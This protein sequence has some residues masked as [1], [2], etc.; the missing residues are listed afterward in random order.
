MGS[1]IEQIEVFVLKADMLLGEMD[2]KE[3]AQ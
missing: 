1:I 3:K 2:N